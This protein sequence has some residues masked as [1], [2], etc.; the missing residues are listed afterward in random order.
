VVELDEPSSFTAPPPPK[1]LLESDEEI[2][3]LDVAPDGK[4]FLLHLA[5]V[6]SQP[7]RVILD[8]LPAQS[9]SEN[10]SERLFDVCWP[11]T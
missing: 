1:V 11:N 3:S 6:E 10:T 7:I 5:P 4:R 2:R 9:L 8:G